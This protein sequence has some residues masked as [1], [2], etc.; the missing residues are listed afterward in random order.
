MEHVQHTSSP[1]AH[2]VQSG[3]QRVGVGLGPVQGPHEAT[4]VF[5]I[6][7]RRH[8]PFYSH[9]LVSLEIS[10]TDATQAAK[11]CE[12]RIQPTFI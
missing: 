4:L 3:L 2:H 6:I 9:Y 5:I 8:L 7:P 11:H 10:S 1:T 12:Y